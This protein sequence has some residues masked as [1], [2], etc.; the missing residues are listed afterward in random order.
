MHVSVC[1]KQLCSC[2]KSPSACY[3]SCKN[4]YNVSPTWGVNI[5]PTFWFGPVSFDK[6]TANKPLWS[7]MEHLWCKTFTLYCKTAT[8]WTIICQKTHGSEGKMVRLEGLASCFRVKY[9]QFEGC[10]FYTQWSQE[11]EKE[12]LQKMLQK[13]Y[14][15]KETELRLSLCMCCMWTQGTWG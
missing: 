8:S 12:V 13:S 11:A 4:L 1:L 14:T 3:P 15:H 7:K 6:T 9:M 5:W 2:R 10:C